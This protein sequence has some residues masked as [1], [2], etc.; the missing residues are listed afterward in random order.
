MAVSFDLLAGYTNQFNFG[1]V[2]FFGSGAYA[3]A[4]LN[5]WLNLPPYFTVPLRGLTALLVSLPIGVT[6][7][8]VKGPYLI[9]VTAAFALVFEK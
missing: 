3:S 2:L 4:I 6:C 8:R 5:K 7:L 1:H 9:L